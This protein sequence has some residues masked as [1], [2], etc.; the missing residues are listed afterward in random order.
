MNVCG[1]H[2]L[3]GSVHVNNRG[4]NG[5]CSIKRKQRNQMQHIPDQFAPNSQGCHDKRNNNETCDQQKQ[6]SQHLL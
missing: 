2:G 4:D 5:A 3:V 6:Q 1:K